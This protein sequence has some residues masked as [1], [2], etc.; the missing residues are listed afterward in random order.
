MLRK[1]EKIRSHKGTAFTSTFT[2]ASNLEEITF[3][4]VIGK[5]ISLKSC[6]KLSLETLS[7]LI[8]CLYDY[9]DSSATHTCTLGAEN[10][11][12]LTD[13][14]KLAVTTKGWTLA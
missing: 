6:T 13:E 2:G 12:K 11:A 4:G 3:E 10:L 8:D 1:I 14:Q 9:S 5:N 7:N